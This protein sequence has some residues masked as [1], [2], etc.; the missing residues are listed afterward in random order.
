[1]FNIPTP[2][3][4]WY[5]LLFYSL[6][7]R[8]STLFLTGA[9]I[10]LWMNDWLTGLLYWLTDWLVVFLCLSFTSSFP[11]LSH[12]WY[13]LRLFKG[14]PDPPIIE[15]IEVGSNYI[16]V[17]WKQP[18]QND[19]SP[20]IIVLVQA[21]KKRQPHDWIN[22]TDTNLAESYCVFHQVESNTTYV[23]RLF[24]RNVVGYSN[25]S[26]IGETLTKTEGVYLEDFWSM[27]VCCSCFKD[28]TLFSC[29]IPKGPWL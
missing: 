21:R 6:K 26:L 19:V 9:N 25:T 5:N 15:S 13:L 14:S 23:I 7:R 1:M 24:A 29:N 17:S 22:C 20:L 28:K 27:N 16:N 8:R 4:S 18:K 3:F 2:I 12:Q 11:R 10:S